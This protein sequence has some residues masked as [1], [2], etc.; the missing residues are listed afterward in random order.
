MSHL[1]LSRQV[2]ESIVIGENTTVTV[3][4]V[5]GDRVKLSIV[6]PQEVKILRGEIAAKKEK[7]DA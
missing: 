2:G 1:V 4:K 6:A 7:Q 5:T 3:A